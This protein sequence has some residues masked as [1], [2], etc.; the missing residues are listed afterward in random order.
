MSARRLNDANTDSVRF[1][2]S[3]GT[4]NRSNRW[5]TL[6]TTQIT[7][8]RLRTAEAKARRTQVFIVFKTFISIC[9]ILIYSN[10]SELSAKLVGY[11]IIN[12]YYIYIYIYSLIFFP[13]YI[14]RVYFL[15]LLLL[16]FLG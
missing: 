8:D 3:N 6:T 2:N 12:I 10:Y 4:Q 5:A 7:N 16:I 11:T 13:Y 1:E 15:L 14:C 9:L